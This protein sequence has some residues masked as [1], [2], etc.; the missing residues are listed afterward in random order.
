[1]KESTEKFEKK[2][3]F[4][5]IMLIILSFFISGCAQ[6]EKL[7]KTFAITL[8]SDATS[9]GAD[10]HFSA[11]IAFK[12][13]NLVDGYASYAGGHMNENWL[14]ECVADRNIL[15]WEDKTTN[16]TCDERLKFMVTWQTNPDGSM[17]S[18]SNDYP[19]LTISEYQRLIENK[20]I[21][22]L[23]KSAE[24][25]CPHLDTCYD[26]SLSV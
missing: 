16:G 4:L 8:Y 20:L 23:N 12:D 6:K 24:V 3:L 1:M 15:T 21:K 22:H 17:T 5:F 26:I 7:P 19:P 25:Q 11:T 9:S 18:I 13:G 14:Y 2:T 10:R